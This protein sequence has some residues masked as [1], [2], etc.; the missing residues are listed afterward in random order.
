MTE[1]ARGAPAITA[2]DHSMR[3]GGAAFPGTVTVSSREGPGQG[4]IGAAPASLALLRPHRPET[5]LPQW[6]SRM[7]AMRREAA[8]TTHLATAHVWAMGARIGVGSGQIPPA[9]APPGGGGALA[10]GRACYHVR[11][12]QSFAHGPLLS[13]GLGP[14]RCSTDFESVIS[15]MVTPVAWRSLVARPLTIRA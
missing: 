9:A 11:R 12:R 8:V 1:R 6:R 5:S 15:A 13:A 3:Q 7:A 4:A 10:S 14:G 2:S